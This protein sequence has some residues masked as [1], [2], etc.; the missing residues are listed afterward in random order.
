MVIVR[1]RSG[2]HSVARNYIH[3]TAL[4]AHEAGISVTPIKNDGSKQPALASWREYQRRRA[5][6]EEIDRWFRSGTLGIAFI[7]GAMSGNLEALDFDDGRIFD[8][9]LSR[10]QR[11][12]TLAALYHHLSWGYLEATPSGGRH[13]LYRC[14][15][16]IEGNQKLASRPNGDKV[17]TLVETR[18]EGGLIIVA[19]SRGKVHP[20]GRSYILLRGGVS[21]IRTITAHQRDHL[22]ASAR[23]FNEIPAAASPIILPRN[24]LRVEDGL[25]PGD[26]FNLQTSWEDVLLPHRW[27]LVRYVGTEGH[28]RRPG[29]EGPGISA[30][31]NYADSDLLYVFSTSTVFEA[32]RGYSKFQAFALLNHSGDF[33]AAARAL[34]R[35]SL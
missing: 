6:R 1:P 12:Q 23:A 25:R 11:D 28:W 34:A 30:T 3:H 15:N 2:P 5:S 32:E 33:S 9:W 17:K 19:P 13:L 35:S 29:K 4:Q 22:L 14:D 24:P 26:L 7:T 16:N 31:T 27:Q 8:A 18:G 20:S 10:V 21:S